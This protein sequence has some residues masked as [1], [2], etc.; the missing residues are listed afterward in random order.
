MSPD[1]PT[2]SETS[3][4]LSDDQRVKTV[5]IERY[6][7]TVILDASGRFLDIAQVSVN[8]DFRSLEQRLNH[9]HVFDVDDFYR[10]QD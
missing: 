3:G 10:R 4:P 2:T 1:D 8:A 6:R 7:V 5:E 9:A